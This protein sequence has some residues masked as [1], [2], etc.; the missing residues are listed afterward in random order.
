MTPLEACQHLIDLTGM[1]YGDVI[2]TPKRGIVVIGSVTAKH[3]MRGPEVNC[4]RR[5]SDLDDP[6]I[7]R[8]A[9]MLVSYHQL[10]HGILVLA[11]HNGEYRKCEITDLRDPDKPLPQNDRR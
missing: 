6:R 4:A 11:V 1:R 2:V 3:T 9:Q 5:A 7:I 10:T 8:T